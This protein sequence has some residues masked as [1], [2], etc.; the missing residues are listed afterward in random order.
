MENSLL[1]TRRTCSTPLELIFLFFLVPSITSAYK[2]GQDD[3]KHGSHSAVRKNLEIIQSE[4]A[5]LTAELIERAKIGIDH[6]LFVRIENNEIDWVI[7]NSVFETL[8]RMK[9]NVIVASPDEEGRGPVLE[10]GLAEAG[11]SYGRAFRGSLFG[12]QLAQ[13]RIRTTISANLRSAN[14]EVLFAGNLSRVFIDTVRAGD[15]AELETAGIPFTHGK[16][17]EEGFFDTILEPAIIMGA[18][19]VAI[20]LFFTVRS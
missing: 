14:E 8:K 2:L 20:Y 19:A 4:I 5:S 18:A 17:P 12:K 1:L 15:I 9:Y 11:V 16:P 6:T 13:R 3:A 10:I 7:R